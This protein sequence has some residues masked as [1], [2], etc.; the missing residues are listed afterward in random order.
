MRMNVA[1]KYLHPEGFSA[2]PFF[3]SIIFFCL[4][5]NMDQCI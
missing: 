5:S 2:S 3:F 1:E 4:Y